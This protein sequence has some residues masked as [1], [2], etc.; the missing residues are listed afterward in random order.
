MPCLP[1]SIPSFIY[2]FLASGRLACFSH[3][4]I[5][6]QRNFQNLSVPPQGDGHLLTQ[7]VLSANSQQILTAGHRM[8][9]S[10]QNIV[11]HPD[12]RLIARAAVCLFIHLIAHDP[13]RGLIR[14]LH[15]HQP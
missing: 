1:H 2:S 8:P 9:V 13:F 3:S 6:L 15:N 14:D 7:I 10:R 5:Q 12:T 11:A 4:F